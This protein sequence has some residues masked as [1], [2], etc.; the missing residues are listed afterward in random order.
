MRDSEFVEDDIGDIFQ[1][2]GKTEVLVNVRTSVLWV[3]EV[4]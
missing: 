3:S 2:L 4:F 1:L